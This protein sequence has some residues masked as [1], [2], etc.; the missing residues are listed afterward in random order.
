MSG[1]ELSDAELWAL[2][3]RELGLRRSVR[4]IG[5]CVAWGLSGHEALTSVVEGEMDRGAV[6]RTL[7]DLKRVVTAAEREAGGNPERF[8]RMT[9]RQFADRIAAMRG[10]IG[11]VRAE[12]SA[13]PSRPG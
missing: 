10:Q 1:R 8:S 7:V 5:W 6:T 9:L 12:R 2:M 3:R 4:L 13:S 11:A